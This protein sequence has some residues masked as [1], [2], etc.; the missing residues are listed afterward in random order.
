MCSLV[1][2]FFLKKKR[3]KEQIFRVYASIRTSQLNLINHGTVNTIRLIKIYI[4]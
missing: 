2:Q 3:K 4:N 1:I